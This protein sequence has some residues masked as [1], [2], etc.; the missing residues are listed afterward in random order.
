MLHFPGVGPFYLIDGPEQEMVLLKAEGLHRHLGR[1]YLFLLGSLELLGVLGHI[2]RTEL[3]RP[4]IPAV[5][6]S[7]RAVVARSSSQS[8]MTGFGFVKMILPTR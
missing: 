7:H 4:V 5:V 8:K 2:S 3:E 1:I 6:Q